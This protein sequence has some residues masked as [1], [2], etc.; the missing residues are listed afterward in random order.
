MAGTDL[1]LEK[2]PP[3]RTAGEWRPV[4]LRVLAN[5]G[6]VRA[7]CEA[8]GITRTA[9]YDHRERSAPFAAAWET[10]LEDACDVLE[11]MARKRAM[12]TSDVLLIFLLKAH[13]PAKYR[14]TYRHEVT[15][16]QG[17]PLKLTI[18]V[19]HDRGG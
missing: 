7:A 4:F 6:N 19:V 2:R 5:S 3:K 14:D 13:R 8:A 10:A 17:G 18:E 9:A 16:G 15:D 11:A 12:D 1:T